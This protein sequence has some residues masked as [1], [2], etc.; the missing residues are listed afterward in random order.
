MAKTESQHPVNELHTPEE[1]L[2][3]AE[4]LL[5]MHDPKT[6]RAA[7]LEAVTALEAY[8]RDVVFSVLPHRI[9]P[10]LVKWLEDKTKMDFQ[11]R[12][13]ILTPIA[14]GSPVDKQSRLWQDYMQAREI[15]NAVTHAGRKVSVEK[16]RFVLRTVHAWLAYIGSTAELERVLI[17]LKS[18]LETCSPVRSGWDAEREVSD[19]LEK[20]TPAKIYRD[21]PI[22]LGS[23]GVRADVVLQ[24]GTRLVLVEIK[25]L[26]SPATLSSLHSAVER[27]V[28]MMTAS[29]Q[30]TQGAAVLIHDGP[31]EAGVPEISRHHAGRVLAVVIGLAKENSAPPSA[32]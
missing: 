29:P 12:L 28:G 6:T 24:F 11:C 4:Y 19:Y 13:S 18:W 30:I 25:Y 14:T 1:L 7:V 10:L 20:S 17:G 26:T 5:A 31:I 32:V 2:A 22:P 15:R 3:N 8:V 21:H 9:D 23:R 16:A 27:L